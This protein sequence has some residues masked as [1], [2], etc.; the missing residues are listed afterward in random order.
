MRSSILNVTRAIIVV[1]ALA[2]GA[3]SASAQAQFDAKKFFEKLQADG[4][5]ATMMPSMV[6]PKK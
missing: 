3:A 2:L 6:D 5:S 1:S 4:A